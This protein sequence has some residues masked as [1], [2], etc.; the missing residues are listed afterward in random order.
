MSK[1]LGNPMTDHEN[2]CDGL[3]F[4]GACLFVLLLCVLVFKV[5]HE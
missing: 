2:A 3:V 4:G 5:C 1:N